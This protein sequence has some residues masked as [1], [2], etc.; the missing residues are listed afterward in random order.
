MRLLLQ[1]A[2]FGELGEGGHAAL[3]HVAADAVGEAD[4]AGSSEV[5]AGYEQQVVGLGP[6]YKLAF[7]NGGLDLGNPE[8]FTCPEKDRMSSL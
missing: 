8:A 5:A 3:Y 6:G 1:A 4:V 7:L 2:L